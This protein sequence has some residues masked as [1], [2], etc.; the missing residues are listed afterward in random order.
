MPLKHLAARKFPTVLAAAELEKKRVQTAF[1]TKLTTWE[2]SDR[3]PRACLPVPKLLEREEKFT[4][5]SSVFSSQYRGSRAWYWGLCPV[6]GSVETPVEIRLAGHSAAGT[7]HPAPH[8]YGWVSYPTPQPTAL[9]Q[10]LAWREAGADL[11]PLCHVVC[12]TDL[13]GFWKSNFQSPLTFCQRPP[14]TKTP[15]T[16]CSGMSHQT[17]W[18]NLSSL[19]LSI[20][21]FELYTE[22]Y[23]IL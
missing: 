2:S 10:L 12:S 11:I 14:A 21:Y 6:L 8:L 9:W 15:S 20:S 13:Y 18:L 22:K 7:A 5:S 17:C 1:R 3:C 4:I 16:C 23:P 19:S